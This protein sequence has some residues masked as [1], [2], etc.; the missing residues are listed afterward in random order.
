M[1]TRNTG[2]I[3]R[4]DRQDRFGNYSA[5]ARSWSVDAADKIRKQRFTGDRENQFVAIS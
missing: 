5:Y 4:A 3:G 2:I 1:Q